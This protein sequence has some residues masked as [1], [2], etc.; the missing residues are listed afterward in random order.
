MTPE[1]LQAMLEALSKSGIKVAGDLVLE[2]HVKHEVANVEPGG[3]GIQI[4]N[5]ITPITNAEIDAIV[6]GNCAGVPQDNTSKDSRQAIIDELFALAE[7]G[8][9]VTGI[10]AEDI[11]GM[12]TV[13]LGRDETP[14]NEEEKEM[15]EKL[16]YMLEHGRGGNRIRVIWQNLVGY[17]W[18]KKLLNAKSAPELNK[19]FFG[20]KEGSDNINKGRNGR[21]AEVTPLLDAYVP[22]LA[23]KR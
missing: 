19:S 4:N 22:K 5:S 21:L 3:I 13:V 9:W 17:F 12:L 8:Y 23:K 15:S 7:K 20:D 2:K 11:N 16:W 1:E 10:T 18:N 6:D 14:L